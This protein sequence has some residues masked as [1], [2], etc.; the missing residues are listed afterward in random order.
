MWYHLQGVWK[1]A[2]MTRP[3]EEEIQN[4]Y[5][6]VAQGSLGAPWN[7]ELLDNPKENTRQLF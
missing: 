7:L 1:Y 2:P 6:L 3:E 5:L 4:N